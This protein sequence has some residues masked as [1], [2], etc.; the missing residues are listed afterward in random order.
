[1]PDPTADAAVWTRRFHPAP[2]ADLRLVCFPHAGGSAGFFHPLSARLG[3]GVEVL[4]VQY[5]GRQDR[6]R[7]PLVDDLH[8]LAD[9]LADVLGRSP[10]GPFAFFGHS[11]GAVVAYEVTRRL[12]DRGGPAPVLLIASGR[13]APSRYRDERFHQLDEAGFVAEMVSL[14]GVPPGLLDDPEIRAMVMDPCRNDYRA[15]ETYRGVPDA[16]PLRVPVSVLFGDRDPRVTPEEA[17]AWRAHTTG[18]FDLTAVPGGGH[19]YLADDPDAAAAR[20]TERIARRV[21]AVH[22]EG[23]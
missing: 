17:E 14:G 21:G 2:E 1:M 12:E 5:P 13:R 20:I 10:G 23:V 4:A 8:V 11:M 3:P 7:E 16:R 18:P 22:A 19:F 9:R 6:R 15:I